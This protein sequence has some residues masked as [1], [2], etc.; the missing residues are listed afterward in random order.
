MIIVCGSVPP[1][2]PLWD[3]YVSKKSY[4]SFGNYNQPRASSSPTELY[5]GNTNPTSL[6]SS[7]CEDHI[8][9]LDASYRQDNDIHVMTD[10]EVVT[11]GD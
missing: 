8:S 3:R 4:K 1:L 2:K 11:S 7:S 5:K 10:V 9:S 6:F